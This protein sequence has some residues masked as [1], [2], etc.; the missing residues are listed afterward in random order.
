MGILT[1]LFKTLMLTRMI[2]DNN[3]KITR[4]MSE[5]SR[6][7]KEQSIFENQLNNDLNLAKAEARQTYET[8]MSGYTNG[9]GQ[10]MTAEQSTAYYTANSV[11]L[12]EYQDK[13]SAAE[14]YADQ[15]KE[16]YLEASK[17]KQTQ[18]E[19][20][21]ATLET[22]GKELA[23]WKEASEQESQDD[24]KNIKPLGSNSSYA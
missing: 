17:E 11:A 3:H 5:I 6:L 19:Q 15:Q 12:R 2:N 10:S 24:I 1:G 22:Y 20:E 18:L 23:Q 16:I 13:I 9:I 14:S 7:T 21:K 8:Q 4:I